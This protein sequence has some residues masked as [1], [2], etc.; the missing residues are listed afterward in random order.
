M[1]IENNTIVLIGQLRDNHEERRVATIVKP[2]YLMDTNADGK[3]IPA[4]TRGAKG[5]LYVAKEDYLQGKTIN[6]AYAVGDLCMIHKAKS[7]NKIALVLAAGENVAK[8]DQLISAGD[9]TVVKYASD[10][11]SNVVAQSTAVTNTTTETT[12]SNGTVTIPANRLKA[13]DNIRISGRVTFPTTNSTDTALIKLK[14]GSTVIFATAATDVADADACVFEALLT[15]R[16]IGASG[17]FVASGS[18]S[19]GVPG[20]ATYRAF[21]LVSTAIDT[22]AA[23]SITVTCTWSVASAS[24]IAYLQQLSTNIDPVGAPGTGVVPIAKVD[25]AVDLSAEEDPDFVKAWI[26]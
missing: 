9:G 6:D 15:I 1:S 21:S 10:V 13:G 11:L 3:V 16:T 8:G 25:V 17:T 2:G 24:N 7:G 14:I 5:E 18:F 23:Q 20:T 12:F 26:L 4:A 19:I 22:T